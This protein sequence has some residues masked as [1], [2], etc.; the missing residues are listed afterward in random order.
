MLYFN[1]IRKDDPVPQLKS[2]FKAIKVNEK[3]HRRNQDVINEIKTL[4]KKFNDS[5][6]G[7][8]VEAAKKVL[9]SLIKKIN[10][11]ISKGILHKKAA[12]RKISRIMKKAARF[13]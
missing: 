3:K 13:K 4:I 5:A 11:A 6:V 1:K 10:K 7:K 2:A 8:D 9:P 12:S